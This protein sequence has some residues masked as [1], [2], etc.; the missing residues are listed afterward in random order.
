MSFLHHYYTS[1]KTGIHGGTGFQTYSMSLGITAQEEEEINRLGMYTTPTGLSQMAD[2]TAIE[3]MY[4]KS[5]YFYPLKSGR[6]VMGLSQ[7]IGRDYSGRFGNYFTHSVVFE[8]NDLQGFPIEFVQS[9]AFRAGLTVEEQESMD[10]PKPLPS[11][12][13]FPKTEIINTASV[14]QFL[15]REN[16]SERLK[17]LI[18]AVIGYQQDKRRLVIIDRGEN[19]PYW[20]AA[21]QYVLPE[22]FALG[23]PFTTYTND[24]MRQNALIC[25]VYHNETPSPLWEQQFYVFDFIRNQVSPVEQNRYSDTVVDLFLDD[26]KELIQLQSFIELTGWNK[27]DKHLNELLQLY[28]LTYYGSQ[29]MEPNEL[30]EALSVI[31]ILE[32][33]HGAVAITDLMLKGWAK[34]NTELE[35]FVLDVPSDFMQVITQW[36]FRVASLT[37]KNEHLKLAASFFYKSW[38]QL[39]IEKGEHHQETM[40]YYHNMMES[41]KDNPAFSILALEPERLTEVYGYCKTENSHLLPL[42]IADFVQH[43]QRLN[44]DWDKLD[45]KWMLQMLHL[46]VAHKIDLSGIFQSLSKL[47]E[48]FVQTIGL[49]VE[50]YRTTQEREHEEYLLTSC[51]K[52]IEEGKM[53]SQQFA[54]LILH[55]E[56]IKMAVIGLLQK[57]MEE[58]QSSIT[59]LVQLQERLL[60]HAD[61]GQMITE[62]LLQRSV[63]ELLFIQGNAFLSEAKQLLTNKDL[64]NLVKESDRILLM[65]SVEQ[66]LPFSNE[67]SQWIDLLQVLEIY[68]NSLPLKSSL[69]LSKLLRLLMGLENQKD[70]KTEFLTFLKEQVGELTKEQYDSLLLWR[71]PLLSQLA[72]KKSRLLIMLYESLHCSENEEIFFEMIMNQ[73]TRV[74]KNSKAVLLAAFIHC[75]V[76]HKKELTERQ[77]NYFIENSSLFKKVKEEA[78]KLSNAEQT[79][80]YLAKV[81]DK[82]PDKKEGSLISRVKSF[83]KPEKAKGEG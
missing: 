78:S 12:A 7:Y 70:M 71:F 23:I 14:L 57:Q 51:L 36:W 13:Q 49:L 1:S 29:S 10:R 59:F 37:N 16:R 24:P 39:L 3:Q 15:Q 69:N 64:M 50:H 5:F 58:S 8:K 9:Q 45:K 20:I 41:N 22:A 31:E 79:N 63:Q 77:L 66:K 55:G 47:E 72:Y 62:E 4:P 52:G 82:I 80:A 61:Y 76:K 42:F 73:S 6:Y 11:T 74:G 34:D 32:D 2:E 48:A 38:T 81:Q 56:A 53:S 60:S 65:E 68:R 17:Q 19:I 35:G 67:I 46:A 26:R 43:A 27:I 18:S 25:G 30:R 33:Q 44:R 40:L 83:L 75:L 28:R 54:K 21:V